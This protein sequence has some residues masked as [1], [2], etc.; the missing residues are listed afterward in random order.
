MQGGVERE[1]FDEAGHMTLCGEVLLEQG[2]A[3][4]RCWTLLDTT[5]HCWTLQDDAGHCS[6]LLDPDGRCWILMDAAGL[7][8]MMLDTA[9]HCW[10][11]SLNT[12]MKINM[13]KMIHV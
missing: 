2:D 3:A 11:L 12:N 10:M 8:R 5:G 9:E 6:T 1:K 7:C 13:I 4:G